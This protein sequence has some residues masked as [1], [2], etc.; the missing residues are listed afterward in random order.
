ME[1][2]TD[3]ISHKIL[4]DEDTVMDTLYILSKSDKSWPVSHTLNDLQF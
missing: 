3:W 1:E 2:E 4:T